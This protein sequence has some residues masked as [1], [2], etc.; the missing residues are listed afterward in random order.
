MKFM[1]AVILL[2]FLVNLFVVR[3]DIVGVLRLT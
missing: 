3:P 1:V 2:C